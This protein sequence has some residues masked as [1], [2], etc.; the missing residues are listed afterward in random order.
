MND[1]DREHDA[2]V[3]WQ[4]IRRTHF[5]HT[6]NLV[7]TLTTASLAFAVNLIVARKTTSV[8][9]GKDAL[10]YSLGF[11]LLAVAA[12]LATNVSRLLDFRY[13]AKAAR[14]RELQ[15][16][17]DAGS[18]LTDDQTSHAKDASKHGNWADRLGVL[19]WCLL[20]A[21]LTAFFVGVLLLTCSVRS[22]H[23]G[24]GEMLG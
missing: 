20:I 2:F 5:G 11:L 22:R 23:F 10:S 8:S 17:A 24:Q 4:D 18:V 13:S 15:A 19:S 21:Q 14:G 9:P 3:R 16:R 12:G 7:L 1:P 6:V